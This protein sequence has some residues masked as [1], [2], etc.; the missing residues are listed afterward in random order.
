MV[1]CRLGMTPD[2]CSHFVM[3]TRSHTGS[4]TPLRGR[5]AVLLTH[6][7]HHCWM[8]TSTCPRQIQVSV[9]HLQQLRM[10]QQRPRALWR[11]PS[12]PRK[13]LRGT[14]A[15]EAQKRVSGSCNVWY[16]FILSSCDVLQLIEP[17]RRP[18]RLRTRAGPSSKRGTS[19]GHQGALC[20]IRGEHG[21]RRHQCVYVNT[22]RST[23][24]RSNIITGP[25][26]RATLLITYIWT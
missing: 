25:P 7:P 23:G 16:T 2:A 24:P 21:C 1:P 8:L 10:Q 13:H 3:H 5:A 20:G 26:E 18:Q 14:G 12:A 15:D 17:L 11:L 4:T 6:G 19:D 22:S 9:G